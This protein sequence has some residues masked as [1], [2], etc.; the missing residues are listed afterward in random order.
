M[1]RAM[2][3]RRRH[4]LIGLSLFLFLLV[5]GRNFGSSSSRSE[6][7]ERYEDV[8]ENGR[9][10]RR[11]WRELVA[12]QDPTDPTGGGDN[13]GGVLPGGDTTTGTSTSSSTSS[14]STSSTT[15]SDTSTSTTTS[16][17][18]STTS[19]STDTSTKTKEKTT[20][21]STPVVTVVVT[22]NG[23]TF[24]TGVPGT[25]VPQDG[26][27]NGG[28]GGG[29]SSKTWIIIGAVVGGVVVL[30]G[31]LLLIFRLSQKRFSNLDD[32]DGGAIKWPE[33]IR[34]GDSSTLNP[35]VARRREGAGVEMSEVGSTRNSMEGDSL[36]GS[37]KAGGA[38]DL[39]RNQSTMSH[40]TMGYPP[41]QGGQY[42]DDPN[43]RFY[44]PYLGPGG[45]PP[46]GYP[47]QI[48]RNGPSPPP[49]H[50]PHPSLSQQP[51]Y[52]PPSNTSYDA[53]NPYAGTAEPYD[54][55]GA[56]S[57]ANSQQGFQSARSSLG[58]NPNMQPQYGGPGQAQAHYGAGDDGYHVEHLGAARDGRASPGPN[59]ALGMGTTEGRKTPQ[60]R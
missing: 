15:S 55:A 29:S 21:F 22:E 44:D 8:R 51:Q 48:Y 54:R 47:A 39:S 53:H 24:S 31:A 59:Q 37:S 38:M 19:S 56:A 13:G 9:F 1:A 11:D 12:R 18:S 52:I 46:T 14:S 27:G 5:Q 45:A 17:S 28:K 34:D 40:G 3:I 33:L 41:N 4:Y 35:M 23:S 43:Q 58:F 49:G 10:E 25:P 42:Y 36:H 6:L 16:S 2:A 50:Q 32:D 7:K 57:P 30:A 60:L 26:E 20:S